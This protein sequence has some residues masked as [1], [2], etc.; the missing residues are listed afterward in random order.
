MGAGPAGLAAAIA[1]SRQGYHVTTID[2]ATPPIDKACGE[3]LMP[4]GIQALLSLGVDLPPAMGRQ[5]QG[6]RFCWEH[7]TVSADFPGA[8][9]L[10]LRRTLL[11][12]LLI[13]KAQ[14]C[15]VNLLWGAKHV[16]LSKTGVQVDGRFVAAQFVV[17]ADGQN[18][19]MRREIGLHRGMRVSRR[20]G[21]RRHYRVEPWSPYVEVHWRHGCQ[22][23]VTPT[24]EDEVCL[25]V[26][27]KS[28]IRLSDALLHFP[29]LQHR[30]AKGEPVTAEKGGLSVSRKLRSVCRGPRAL[31]GDAAGSVDAITGEGLSLSFRQS[32]AL[33]RALKHGHVNEYR[34]EHAAIM[35]GP[36]TMQRILLSL[37]LNSELQ[38]RSLSVLQAHPDVFASLLKAHIGAS[39]L[40]DACVTSVYRIL[41]RSLLTVPFFIGGK[42]PSD[43]L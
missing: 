26:I 29:E 11:H 1:L 16:L 19:G 10:A 22:I 43:F 32:L 30:L 12:E 18:S 36:R 28:G 31:I 20:I 17:G 4:A 40:L 9:A 5:F 27:S 13:S 2:C 38:R 39:S 37:D 21:F 7:S 24:A 41:H 8:P 42:N 3:G 33:A 15:G 6:I 14:S 34:R 25:A 23:Y 35:R